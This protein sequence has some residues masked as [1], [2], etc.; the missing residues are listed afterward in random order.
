MPDKAPT[1][2]DAQTVAGAPAGADVNMETGAGSPTG[3]VAATDALTG[4]PAAV[5]ATAAAV[6]LLRGLSQDNSSLSS[7]TGWG[8]GGKLPDI[9]D[10][11]SIKHLFGPKPKAEDLKKEVIWRSQ[12]LNLNPAPKKWSVPQ[13]LLWLFN[14]P[15]PPG[16]VPP[17][18][19]VGT[20]E[21]NRAWRDR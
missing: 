17:E 8:E 18:R 3:A 1:C 10:W 6:P 13:V 4:P 12:H 15:A 9:K 21:R 20:C 14:N 19:T 11:T 16:L 2:A 7:I 5:S